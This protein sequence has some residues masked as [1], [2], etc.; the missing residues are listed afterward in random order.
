MTFLR[1]TRRG[2]LGVALASAG[3]RRLAAATTVPEAATLLAPG[4]EQ[5]GA[6]RFAERA[7][8]GL[9]RSLP[10]AAAVRVQVVGGPDGITAANRFATATA[11]DQALLLLLPGLAAQA[12]L[13]GDSRA[14]FEP[15]RWPALAGNLQ[16]AIVA[17]R[18]ALGGAGRGALGQPARLAASGPAGPD[19]AALLA[20]DLLGVAA[21]PM[22]PPAGSTAEAAIAARQ[23]DALVLTGAAPL[24]RAAALGLT[25]WFSLDGT[26]AAR[27]PDLAEVPSLGDLLADPAHPML[28]AACH[29]AGA[30][31]R[32]RGVLVLQAM[33]PSDSVALWRG[34]ARRWVEAEPEA[35]EPGTRRVAG[36]AATAAL[37]ALCPPPQV[38]LAYRE[39]LQRRLGWQAG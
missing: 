37:A 22:L 23:A 34:A 29:A 6:A 13:V 15:R 28:L 33:T 35:P 11:A 9:G 32:V 8:R 10:Q 26:A 24:E 21:A 14:R 31:L 4:P 38:A 36:D 30:A 1:A 12:L 39:W 25:P 27:E 20:L 19:M 2:V 5:G 7:A 16:A 17:G 18:G 3:T